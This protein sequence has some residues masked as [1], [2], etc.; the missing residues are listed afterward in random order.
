MMHTRAQDMWREQ[1]EAGRSIRKKYGLMSAL[2]Y[3]VR[4]K[5]L[6]FAEAAVSHRNFAEELPFFV[7][8]VRRVFTR[9][10]LTHYLVALAHERV[11]TAGIEEDDF[12]PASIVEARIGRLELIGQMLTNEHLGTS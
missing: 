7:S 3:L 9:Q 10:E 6:N 4:E 5:L 1:C 12:E 11:E 8:E 2:D